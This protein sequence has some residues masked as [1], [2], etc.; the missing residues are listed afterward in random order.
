MR[1]LFFLFFLSVSL[2]S[3]AQDWQDLTYNSEQ[4]G[5]EENPLKGLVPLYS[6][7]NEFPHSIRGLILGFDAVA[8]GENTFDW[9]LFDDFLDETGDG[10][11]F[12]YMQVNVDMGFNRS[13]LP[14]F[15][16]NVE[17]FYY[18]GTDP[19]DGAGVPSVVVNYNNEEM[20]TAMLNF[21][22][23]FGAKYNDDPR[24]FLVHYGLYGIFGEWDI[25]FGKK[26]IP[27]GEE[28]EM[29]PENQ[30]RITDAFETAFS[31]KNLLARFPEN[32]PE[33]QSVGYSDGLYFGGSVSDNPA[34]QWFFHPK[35]VANNADQN[36]KTYPIGGEVDPDVQPILWEN[37]PNTVIGLPGQEQ[38]TEEVFE[39]THPTF[40]FQDFM[41]NDITEVSHPTMW[42]NALK[43]TKRTGYTFH[44]NEVRLTAANALPSIE[45]NIQ[46]KGLA[47][48]YADWD[49]EFAYLDGNDV[50]QTL[51]TSSSWSL[52]NI[53][54]DNDANYRSFISGTTVP[55]GTYT[56]LLRIINPLET[57]SMA[58]KPVR[59]ANDTQDA[60]ETGWLTLGQATIIDG[61]VGETPVAV[62]SMTVSPATATI[63]LNSTLQL[64]ANVLPADAT[65]PAVTWSS[66]RPLT[67]S[68]DQNGLVTSF[69]QGGEIIMTATSQ[70]GGIVST[71]TVFVESYWEIPGRVEAEGY[72]DV[73]M[74]QVG[75]TPDGEEGG[76]VLGFINDDTWMEYVV[77]VTEAA[78]FVLDARASSP[79]GV[80]TID[81]LDEESNVLTTLLLAPSTSNYD[82]YATYTTDPF[83][84]PAGRYTLRLDV[85]ASNFNLNWMDFRIDPCTG[86]DMSLIGTACDDGDDNTT[87][88][89]YA[90]NCECVGTPAANFTPIPALIQ[91]EDFFAINN[92][93]VNDAPAGEE[94]GGSILGF[95]GDDTWMDYTISVTQE[96]EYV[97]DFRAASPFGVGV[98]AILNDA[99]ETLTTI[100][101]TP[102]TDDFD[103][104]GLYTSAPF[105]LPMG[106]YRLRLDVVASNFNLNWIEFRYA[107]SCE[108][109]IGTACDDE[110]A[111]TTNDAYT[112]DC[113][114]VGLP[115]AAF[116]PIPA[117]I[118]AEDFY[119]VFNVQVNGAPADEAGG[120]S[121]L[122]FINDDTWMEYGVTVS[123]EAN[124]VLDFRASSPFAVSVIDVLNEA[125]ETVSTINLAPATAS[126]NDYA[127]FT[128]EPF[129]LPAGSFFLRLDVVAS[130]FNLN[131]IEF[132]LAPSCDPAS[133][134]A[135]DDGNPFTIDDVIT[136]G[137]ECLGTLNIE[138]VAI[139]ALIQAEDYVAVNAAQIADAPAGE[140]GGGSVLGFTSDDTWMDYAV[141]VSE[142]DNFVVDFRASNPFGVTVLA[143][144]NEAGDM[145]TRLPL[146]P[147]TGGDYDT[148]GTFTT[149]QFTLPAGDYILRVD[150]IASAFNLNWI[151]FKLAEDCQDPVGTAC[152][153]GDIETTLDRVTAT[154]ECVGI[155][156][157]AF[158]N[159]PALI[160]AE[161]F[162]TVNEAQVNDAPA[163]EAGGGSVLGFTSDDTWMDYAISVD[164]ELNKNGGQNVEFVVDIRA[165]NPFGV[166][167]LAVVNEAGDTLTRIPLSPDTGGDYDTYATYTSDPFMLPIGDQVLRIDVVASAFNLNWIEFKTTAALP[168]ELAH[169]EATPRDKDIM[170]N[171]ATSF[172]SN[173]EGFHLERKNGPDEFTRIAWIDGSGTSNEANQYS[174]ADADIV[175]NTDYFYR[176]VQ[177]DTDGTLSYSETVTARLNADITDY[178]NLLTVYPNPAKDE[179]TISWS[180]S[181]VDATLEN[182]K[183]FNAFGKLV[184]QRIMDFRRIDLSS[185][186]AG[187][188]ILE[189]EVE[190]KRITKKIVKQ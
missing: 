58:A 96:T 92:A 87:N 56:F 27:E 90:D 164:E 13:D 173:N 79:S 111:S 123:E 82:T 70:D 72:S 167:V 83:S 137:C 156:V 125:G 161:D 36:W 84:L 118:E 117:L 12:G 151:E 152:D 162:Y 80:G 4:A 9:T 32:V 44:V 140:A 159:I 184:L 37:F 95:I 128:T 189:V 113:N 131:W 20:M 43:A 104:Y 176:L 11:R 21:I 97:V 39:L 34:F 153:D 154:C 14:D 99:D 57:I 10:G 170:L 41:F 139:P 68:V 24:V 73:F 132:R 143:I 40:L 144:V 106:D 17:R 100:N 62:T 181:A 19:D 115:V 81:I 119:D 89:T 134:T 28:W 187:L 98:I 107:T 101:L 71:A 53:Q 177:E 2:F 8:T 136:A 120:G 54:P 3:Q 109:P 175:S 42:A 180:S 169:F 190:G 185:M 133:G 1:Y 122:G 66:N 188:Y 174:F 160:Q 124:F 75:A 129:T 59:F 47:P 26:F 22:A 182:G 78:S 55:D 141:S 158:T 142:E 33:P 138:Y 88:D 18:D 179:L 61:A 149:D 186:P 126:Y 46:N 86:F 5:L 163:G 30:L 15:L 121:V 168:I 150:V 112:F 110:D 155:P 7:N 91:A 108:F 23:A 183:I 127:V 52:K 25:G 48:M 60:D 146:T 16:D 45:V 148:Y 51:G 157:S 130:A 147:D 63:G 67:A 76:S 94:G 171:W 178:S 49:V 6:V 135:C 165:S 145:L 64:T 35:L 93:Q 166:T 74:A 77:D 103:T 50:L 105:M 65:N 114:C 116:T 172:E 85:V 102:A 69:N 31:N 38:E 29:T